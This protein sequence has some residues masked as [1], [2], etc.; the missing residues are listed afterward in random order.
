VAY[1]IFFALSHDFYVNTIFMQMA[2]RDLP[3]I[4]SYLFYLFIFCAAQTSSSD[5]T[6]CSIDLNK[7]GLILERALFEKTSSHVI[8]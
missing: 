6:D 5:D 3:Q 2:G 4:G 7:F 8:L 1:P